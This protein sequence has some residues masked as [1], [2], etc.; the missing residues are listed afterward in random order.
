MHAQEMYRRLTGLVVF[1]QLLRDPVVAACCEM[2]SARV[3][4]DCGDVS[5]A[6]AGF[7]AALFQSS[8][9]WSRYLRETVLESEN[10]PHILCS[11]AAVMEC[12]PTPAILFEKMFA[13]P[14][15]SS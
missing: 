14:G 11:N 1:R 10:A 7:E 13:L 12:R 5:A 6:C 9:S 4:G 2:L 3:R 15:P 8:D